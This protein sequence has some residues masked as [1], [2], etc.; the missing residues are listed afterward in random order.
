VIVDDFDIMRVAA[1]ELETDAPGS[2]HVHRPLLS[3][4]ALELV[5]PNAFEAAD[6]LESFRILENLETHERAAIIE[7]AELVGPSA[8]PHLTARR[9]PPRLDQGEIVARRMDNVK[10]ITG[11]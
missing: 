1:P 8:L 3:A 7:S 4:A 11:R 10:R 5:Q 2:I 9:V 6:G